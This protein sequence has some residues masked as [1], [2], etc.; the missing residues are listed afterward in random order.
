LVGN[1]VSNAIA[2]G[3]PAVAIT[4]TTAGEPDACS[5]AVH[6]MGPVIPPDRQAAIFQPM[7]RGADVSHRNRS[8]GLGLF[9]VRQIAEAH[10]GR[11]RVD[12]T[13]ER[14]TTFSVN[15]PRSARS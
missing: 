4:V 15:L 14:G 7:T 5:V 6:N 10:G 3:D 2:Y 9:I 11:A 13:P 12:S 1:L 8:V